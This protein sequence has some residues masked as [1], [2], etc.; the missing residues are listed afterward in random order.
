MEYNRVTEEILH[1][2]EAIVGPDDVLLTKEELSN[3]A[4]DESSVKPHNPEVVVRAETTE[5]ASKILLLANENMIPVTPRGGGTGLTGGSIPIYGGML[6]SL[7]K[8]NRILE[9]DEENLTLTVEPGVLIMDIHAFVEERGFMYPPDP[10]QK[11][12]AIGGNISTNAGG[13]RG[14]KYGV[15]RDFVL[16]LEVVLPTGEVTTL[17]GKTVKNSTGYSLMDLIIGAEGTLGIVTKAVLR[18][19]PLPKI[20]VTLFAPYADIQD[21]SRTVSEIIRNKIVPP[22]VEFVDQSSILVAERYLGKPMPR[23]DSPSY[24]LVRIEGNDRGAVDIDYELVGEICLKNNALDVL[25]A[26]TKQNQENIWEGRSCIIDAAKAEGFV[27]VLDCVVPR[28]RIPE[29]I[30]GL[31]DIAEKY[32]VECQNFGHAGDGNVHTN[33]LKKNMNDQEWNEKIPR[34]VDEIYRLSITLGGTIS[35]EHGIG[36]IRKPFLS[37]SRDKVQIELMKGIK[38]LFDPKNILNPGKIFDLD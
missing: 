29:L 12:G 7:E 36:L 14:V 28:S 8:M 11:S 2:L 16:G 34:L 23:N 30:K 19:V 13:M 5:E 6:L 31:N 10:G 3:Y 9:L 4:H 33:V 38:R 24:V 35:G 27:E 22:A 25:V 26:D 32:G 37:M 1:Q 17:G 18:L 20:R 21:A 15:T